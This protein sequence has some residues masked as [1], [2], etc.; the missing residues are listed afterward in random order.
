MSVTGKTLA[1]LAA[2]LLPL[3][4]PAVP[5][6]AAAPP[7]APHEPAVHLGAVTLLSGDHVTV[8]RVGHGLVPTVSPGPGRTGIQF[9][10]TST[11]DALWVVPSD[12]L[13]GVNAG[14]LDRRLFDVT[15]L[16]RAGYGDDRRDTLPLITPGT[17]TPPGTLRRADV[18]TQDF[19]ALDA[20]K[21]GADTWRALRDG[22]VW[23]DG[24]RR[25][26]LDVSVA[27]I[28][29]PAAWRAGY[30]GAGSTVAVLDTGID[31]THPDFAGR[32]GATR[33][34]L[35][36]EPVRD[37][38][39]HGTH[40]AST[41]AGS[42]AASNGRFKGVAPAARL[43]I[44]KVCGGG[45]CPE[46]AIL[47]GM[48]WAVSSGADVVNLSLG[49]TD[50]EEEDPLEAAVNRLSASNGT[51]FVVA[52]GNDGGHGAETV[53]SPASA[54]AALAVGAVDAEDAVA[55][56]SS[57]GPRVH[58]AA[59]KPEIAAP[60]VRITAARSRF[61]GYP[62]TEPGYTTLSGT[63]MATPHVAG[64]AAILAQRHPD[65]T[66]AQL[67]AALMAAAQPVPGPLAVA[68]Q[69]AG[70]VDV[71]RAVTQPVYTSPAAVSAG[72][73]AWPHGDDAPSTH[74]LTYHNTSATPLTLNLAVTAD[75]PDGEPAPAGVF[76]LSATELTVPA[77]GT[78]AVAVT[79]STAIDAAEGVFSARITARGPG[80]AVV[81]TPVAVD[82]EPES[83]DLRLRPVDLT[84]NV[85]DRAFTVLFG[86]D[87]ERYRPVPTVNG[88]GTIRV[89]R[90]TYHLDSVVATPRPF[91]VGTDTSKVV[92]P[93]VQV[94]ADTTLWFDAR[95]AKPISIAI[96]RP[97]VRTAAVAAGYTRTVDNRVL[98][99][100]ILGDDFGRIQ[101]GQ[102][103]PPVPDG[104]LVAS[105]GGAWAVPDQQGD[106][107]ASPVAYHLAWFEYGALP[108]GFRRTVA[109]SALA[110]VDAT[111]REQVAGRS[112]TKVWVSREP[113]YG[114][115]FGFGLP[116]TLP[117]N[118]VEFH[119]TDDLAWS[120]EFQQWR[121]LPTG[122]STESTLVGGVVDHVAGQSYVESWNSAVFGPSL[123]GGD[124][125]VRDGDLMSFQL[126]LYADASPDRY[127]LSSTDSGRIELTR[128]GVLLGENDTPGLGSFE[129]P[130]EPGRYRLATTA[131]RSGVSTLSTTVSAVWE[132][133]SRGPETTRKGGTALPLLVV[134][135]SPPN[136]SD[137][138]DVSDDRI[139]L[140]FSVQRAAGA[141]PADVTEAFV[142]VSFDDGANW[143][144]MPA[145]VAADGT[146]TVTVDHPRGARHVSLRTTA[147]DAAGSTVEQ[148][149]LR[150]YD[151]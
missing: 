5:S 23:L 71:A 55:E 6:A 16:L 69:G 7:P 108:T 84:G 118:R 132:F 130:A 42:G 72:R 95:T 50:T 106:V 77:A 24:L 9:A 123:A 52:A 97:D 40:V 66:G 57:R 28:G 63:S 41:V 131:V 86:V 111:Y 8:R 140:P 129:V 90:G 121:R 17:A 89:R 56:F 1:L 29:A 137:D 39:G 74:T 58:D 79:L 14:R 134:R 113:A 27:R 64:A 18:S 148:T 21:R 104:D 15:G 87:A 127:G 22:R 141:Q 33:S 65:W 105:V 47:A 88:T 135:F 34:F 109:T 73:A 25:P 83:Y 99:T 114:V 70:R 115:A 59:V 92:R 85:T 93:A 37:T 142:S 31:L 78:A 30:D 26:S 51:L 147:R 80:D 45:G 82:R 43:L 119:N 139:V 126:P 2:L 61:S 19:T 117:G 125:A 133:D 91:G 67:K 32:I 136:L 38:D 128:D 20:P 122:M 146:G 11:G 102:V 62:Q 12:A 107:S 96:D 120:A 35:A 53:S 48:Q 13:A 10:T 81:G 143:I 116:L 46:S 144:P 4:L 151:C 100:G 94:G 101:I 138:N 44:G 3:S 68:E 124:W 149:I 103:G 36:G 150:A 60:G 145:S 110:R 49:G 75:G 98:G 76:T 54:D 112:G